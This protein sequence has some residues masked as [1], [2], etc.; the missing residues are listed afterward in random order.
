M[1]HRISA[2]ASS[3]HQNAIPHGRSKPKTVTIKIHRPTA[4]IASSKNSPTEFLQFTRKQLTP[5]L[6]GVRK[7]EQPSMKYT[8][9]TVFTHPR[10][11]LSCTPIHDKQD[12]CHIHKKQMGR[13]ASQQ[14][15]FSKNTSTP[16]A[17]PTGL[18][19][20]TKRTRIP[21]KSAPTPRPKVQ[22][23]Q[24]IKHLSYM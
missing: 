7:R 10:I 22:Q 20:A 1:R 12:C 9:K 18:S 24:E 19:S 21:T 8:C 15:F 4:Y 11:P 3:N 6:L 17:N 5:D 14:L 13:S 2:S 16:H 23:T